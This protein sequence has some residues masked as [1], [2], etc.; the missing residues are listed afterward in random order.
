MAWRREATIGDPTTFTRPRTVVVPMRKSG[1]MREGFPYVSRR[2]RALGIV[3]LASVTAVVAQ[4][5]SAGWGRPE[6]PYDGQYTF[7][8]LRWRSGTYGV[9]V[10]GLATP[11]ATCQ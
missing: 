1:V 11:P 5:R 9:P 2:L 6:L 8:R 10:A 7:V 3:A 4:P